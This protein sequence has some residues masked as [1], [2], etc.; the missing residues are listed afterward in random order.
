MSGDVQAWIEE[1]YN[2][3][4]M[5]MGAQELDIPEIAEPV[6]LKVA[7]DH[8]RRTDSALCTGIPGSNP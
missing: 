6:T 5:P 2:G 1:S 3:V 4:V 7:Q 8:E